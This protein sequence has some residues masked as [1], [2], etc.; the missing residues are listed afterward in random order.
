MASENAEKAFHFELTSG[1]RYDSPSAV[2][3]DGVSNPGERRVRVPVLEW[4]PRQL[5][6]TRCFGVLGFWGLAHTYL[7]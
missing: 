2:E 6:V 7:G 1:T 4:P 5:E 3:F